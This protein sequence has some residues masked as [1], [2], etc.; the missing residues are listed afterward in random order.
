MDAFIPAPADSFELHHT[1]RIKYPSLK[2]FTRHLEEGSTEYWS[3][4]SASI[5]NIENRYDPILS[6]VQDKAVAAH[7][8][9]EGDEASFSSLTK[10]DTDLHRRAEAIAF[11]RAIPNPIEPANFSELFVHMA[12]VQRTNGV[13]VLRLA[14]ASDTNNANNMILVC[15]RK[16][17]FWVPNGGWEVN[18]ATYAGNPVDFFGTVD[19]MNPVHKAQYIRDMVDLIWRQTD[20]AVRHVY[21]QGESQDLDTHSADGWREARRLPVAKVQLALTLATEEITTGSLD[22]E[23]DSCGCCTEKYGT[24]TRCIKLK[25]GHMLCAD[26][27]LTWACYRYGENEDPNCQSCR[28]LVLSDEASTTLKY[29]TDGPGYAFDNRFNIWENSMRSL[30]DLDKHVAELNH[31][32]ITV[33]AELLMRIFNHIRDMDDQEP[34]SS[35]PQHLQPTKMTS[36]CRVLVAAMK[37]GLTKRSGRALV[38][39]ALFK[40]LM[41]RVKDTMILGMFHNTSVRIYNPDALTVGAMAAIRQQALQQKRGPPLGFMEYC[42]RLISRTLQ[43]YH[44]RQCTCAQRGS[45]HYHGLKRY[46]R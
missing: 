41:T 31:E 20:R 8:S 10:A 44:I 34:L 16:T 5:E 38:T 12:V 30:A 19:E 18:T 28:T 29:D 1:T 7:Q 45:D 42:Q 36:E 11:L 39:S 24:S 14:T 23:D 27:M 46:W 17:R 6:L 25:C 33:N 35:T 26:C 22:A 4:S 32:L 43:F 9:R 2:V 21:V 37:F 13:T 3:P 15:E 40:E